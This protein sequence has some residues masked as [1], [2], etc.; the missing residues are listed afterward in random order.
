MATRPV[1]LLVILLLCS[2]TS[3]AVAQEA[4]GDCRECPIPAPEG[5]NDTLMDARFRDGTTLQ[6]VVSA[7]RVLMRE[8]GEERQGIRMRWYDE[9]TCRDTTLPVENVLSFSIGGLGIGGQTLVVP[10]RPA[11]EFF[12]DQGEVAPSTRF[13]ELGGLVGY[14]GPDESTREIGFNSVLFGAELLVAP[15]GDL[16]GERLALALGGGISVESG[17]IRYPLLGHLRFTLA[18]APE[19]LSAER[20]VPNPCQFGR[21]GEIAATVRDEGDLREVPRSAELDSTV[22]YLR[23]K[24]VV[25]GSFRPYLYLEGGLYFDGD[26]EGAGDEPSVNPE[27]YDEYLLGGGLG[28]PVGPLSIAL[29]YRYSRLNLRTPCPACE[30]KMVVN[31]N[32]VHGAV[33]KVGWLVGI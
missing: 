3:V 16:R 1:T 19:V 25:S 31:T 32:N 17:R 7:R 18:G 9:G 11:R 21:E 2:A 6:N 29:G 13:I 10:V 4:S 24:E 23:E 27:E 22:Y 14:G 30:E 8:F 20:L 33:L 15:F 12:R 26:F 28:L 5:R